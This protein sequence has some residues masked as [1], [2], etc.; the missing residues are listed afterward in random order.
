MAAEGSKHSAPMS[1]AE[2]AWPF[3]QTL[4]SHTAS[5]LPR[6]PGYQGGVKGSP[7]SQERM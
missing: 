2:A 4:R 5:L 1:K 6:S 3:T 7:E